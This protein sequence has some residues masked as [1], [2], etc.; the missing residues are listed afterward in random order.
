MSSGLDNSPSSARRSAWWSRIRSWHNW[1][2]AVKLAGVVLIPVIFA[3]SLGTLRIHDRIEEGTEYARLNGVVTAASGLRTTAGD[4]QQER[5]RAAEYLAKG[6]ISAATLQSRFT[7]TDRS[8]AGNAAALRKQANDNLIV[9]YAYDDAQRQLARLPLLRQQVLANQI[10]PVIAVNAYTEIASAVLALDLS[11]VGQISSPELSST[12]NALHAL[13]HISEEMR[14]QQAMVLVGTL[15][16]SFTSD[17]MESLNASENRRLE[18]VDEF[19]AVATPQQRADYDGL[20]STPEVSARENSLQLALAGRGTT[21]GEAGPT[22]L[23]PLMPSTPTWDGQSETAISAVQNLRSHMDNQ[24]HGTSHNLRETASNL[25]GAETVILVV[26]LLL[27][28]AVVVFVARQLLGSLDLLRRKALDI[29]NKQLPRAVVEIR[30]GR[31]SRVSV[32]RV[33]IDT[34]DEIGQVA[35]AFDDVHT[36]AVTLATEQAELRK[37]FSDS[38]VNVSR[39][40]QSL[41]ERQLRLFEQLES[42]EEDPD[43][44][45]T[46]FQLDHL[47]TRMRRNNE[48]LMVLSG[49]DLARRFPQPVPLADLVRAAVSEIEHYPRV[50]VTPL[51][52]SLVLGYVGSDL[53]RLIAELLDN[54]ANFSAP[55]TTVVVSGH[56]RGDGSVGLDIVDRGIGMSEADLAATQEQLATNQEVR[57]ATSRRMGLFVVGRLATR[58][59]VEVELREGPERIGLRAS[60]VL[61]VE[62]LADAAPQTGHRTNGSAHPNGTHR[63][64]LRTPDDALVQQFDWDSA[65]RDATDLSLPTRNGVHLT[66]IAKHPAW[67]TVEPTQ[68]GEDDESEAEPSDDAPRHSLFTPIETKETPAAL[69]AEV[70]V[71]PDRPETAEPE[72]DGETPEGLS[73]PIFDDLASAWFKVSPPPRSAALDADDLHWPMGDSKGTFL[74]DVTGRFPCSHPALEADAEVDWNFSND[75]DLHHAE[76]VS[77]TEPTDYTEV[78]LPRRTPRAH[79]IAGSASTS[80]PVEQGKPQRDPTVSRGRLSSFQQGLRAGRHS[81]GDDHQTAQVDNEA[82]SQFEWSF[83]TDPVAL[84]AKAALANAPTRFTQSGLP[85]RTPRAQLVLGE[86]NEA[87]DGEDTLQ[88]NAEQMRGRLASFQRGVREGRHTLREPVDETVDEHR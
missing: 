72:P 78:G 82:D 39:R 81:M 64:A 12:S 36:Q 37:K 1:S 43:Q 4:L 2:L 75:E 11:L 77:N 63:H 51:P 42:D 71:E 88:R 74:P 66:G 27:A 86:A 3:V 67:S 76:E 54:A 62:L 22:T 28:G 8:V 7:V 80:E 87:A 13:A 45:A 29:A 48:N 19:H 44:L 10:D 18:A 15:R 38:F 60:I 24:L 23:S 79:L 46:L 30:A 83:E 65:E 61:R 26:A 25:A 56:R 50:I 47:A 85:R 58:H 14:I 21:Q 68:N 6:P 16:T 31:G 59:N 17:M 69:H 32:D 34:V 35:R 70:A 55:Q 9:R 5:T 33:P 53:V 52:E 49:A 57:L 20:Y 73:T 84:Q 41:L 40:S